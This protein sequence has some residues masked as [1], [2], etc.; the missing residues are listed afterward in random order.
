[1]WNHNSYSERVFEIKGIFYED[2]GKI[3]ND[4]QQYQELDTSDNQSRES[5]EDNIVYKDNHT[6]DKTQY[7]S[8]CSEN[9]IAST[10]ENANAQRPV[11][12]ITHHT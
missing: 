9:K 10:T 7:F 8:L 12:Q 11:T 5:G 4:K 2:Y 1:M 3:K 6:V